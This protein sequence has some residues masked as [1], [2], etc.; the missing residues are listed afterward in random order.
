MSLRWD[1]ERKVDEDGFHIWTD[2]PL[3]RLART[4]NWALFLLYGIKGNVQQFVKPHM[5]KGNYTHLIE[6]I[7]EAV[8]N[9]KDKQQAR[10]LRKSK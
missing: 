6:A 2:T 4:E 7:D 1:R 9:I 10:Q 8:L 5:S 3:R